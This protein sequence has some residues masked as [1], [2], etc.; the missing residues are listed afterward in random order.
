MIPAR[1]YVGDAQERRRLAVLNIRTGKSVWADVCVRGEGE[2]AGQDARVGRRREGGRPRGALE[3]AARSRKAARRRSRW[4]AR[5]TSRTSGSSTVDAESGQGH[6]HR[7]AARRRMG[8]RRRRAR[9][10]RLR[11]DAGS[12]AHLVRRREGRLAAPL[13]RRRHDRPARRR[14]SSPQAGSRSRASR[15]QPTGSASTSRRARSTRASATSTR[16]RSRA[17]TR[18]AITTM[19]GSNAATPSPDDVDRRHWS[20]RTPTGRPSCT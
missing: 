5:P 3:H 1:H 10:R 20:T 16:C 8:A 13:G 14:S 9:R 18:T 12:A 17:A 4:S 19:T 6:R 7:R 11:L 15:C 2:G